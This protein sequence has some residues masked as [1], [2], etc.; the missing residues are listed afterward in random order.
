MAAASVRSVSLRVRSDMTFSHFLGEILGGAPR[1]RDDRVRRVLVGIADE[2]RRIGDKQIPHV[3][4]LAELV[5]RTA[6][7]VVAHAY[8]ADLVN[9]PAARR[10]RRTV[11]D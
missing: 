5:E 7:P 11:L 9:N 10:D 6:T 1:E 3:V 2:G 4:R 8:G